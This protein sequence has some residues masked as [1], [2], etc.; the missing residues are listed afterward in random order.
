MHSVDR[1]KQHVVERL[2]PDDIG[3]HFVERDVGQQPITISLRQAG[4]TCGLQSWWLFSFFITWEMTQVLTSRPD[5]NFSVGR[6]RMK[7]MR[8]TIIATILTGFILVSCQTKNK[9]DESN[10]ATDTVKSADVE[11]SKKFE[12]D[13]S[14][15]A[16]DNSGCTRGQAESVVKKEVYPDASFKLNDD[17]H[18]GTET[19]ELKEG[20]KLL[21][22]NW[23][24][25]YYVLTF[26]FETNRFQADTTDIKYWMDKAINLMGEI[27]KGLD[28]PLNISGGT[29]ATQEFLKSNK[30]Y[31]LGQEIVSKESEIRDF[32]TLDRIQKL[33]DKRFAIEISYATGPL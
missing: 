25:E 5:A 19:I 9:T 22:K 3:T 15:L 18:S 30:E 11:N 31:H 32:V 20:D 17:N 21:I 12:K 13:T 6:N 8:L 28:A 33:G 27:E 29:A 7:N 4:R 10:A 16:T 24:C 23:G 14:N 1:G 26:R 2:T